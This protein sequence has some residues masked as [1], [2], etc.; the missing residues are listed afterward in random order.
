MRLPLL[1]LSWRCLAIAPYVLFTYSLKYID[2]GRAS[3]L[4]SCEPITATFLGILIYKEIPS[5]IS[6]IGIVLI[7][8]AVVLLSNPNWGKGKINYLSSSPSKSNT[9]ILL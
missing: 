4:A 8:A 5:V 7:L 2:T 9:L 3:I 1:N 6:V